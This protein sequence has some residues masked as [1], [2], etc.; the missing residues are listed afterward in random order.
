MATKTKAQLEAEVAE[1]KKKLASQPAG[2]GPVQVVTV[3][4]QGPA[5]FG[6]SPRGEPKRYFSTI[7]NRQIGRTYVDPASGK[8][9]RAPE[10]LQFDAHWL[11]TDNIA[12][13]EYIESLKDF[14]TRIKLDSAATVTDKKKA[15]KKTESY[16]E[17]GQDTGTGRPTQ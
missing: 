1:L 14:G 17:G 7:R 16:T 3:L 4:P 2:G 6:A 11:T 10:Y 8:E 5:G 12:E 9:S 15:A 13:Q